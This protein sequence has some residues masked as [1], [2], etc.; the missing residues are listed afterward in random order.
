MAAMRIALRELLRKHKDD[1]QV[2]AFNESWC[3]L[4]RM[5]AFRNRPLRSVRVAGCRGA[6]GA[7]RRSGGEHGGGGRGILAAMSGA[8]HTEPVGPGPPASPGAGGGEHRGDHQAAELLREARAD[9]IA[10]MAC[11]QA[12]RRRI[13][14]TNGVVRLH[15]KV[16][17]AMRRGADLSQRAVG[18]V[19]DRRGVERARGRGVGWA[20][21]LQPGV[22]GR[23]R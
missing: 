7:G 22:N 18:P 23:D 8:F 16:K 13:L 9:V 15:R 17:T 20:Q 11:P 3:S 4:G 1:S 21:I 12:H 10:H 6:K 5:E 14:S 2:D 19:A